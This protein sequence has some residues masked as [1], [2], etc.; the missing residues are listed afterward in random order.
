MGFDDL[1]AIGCCH[2][3][4]S[5]AKLAGIESDTRIGKEQEE[6]EKVE[7]PTRVAGIS[8]VRG[9]L[10][11]DPSD[12]VAILRGLLPG[13]SEGPTSIPIIAGRSEEQ[14]NPSRP[15]D[16][17]PS[18]LA[19]CR[20]QMNEFCSFEGILLVSSMDENNDN[21]NKNAYVNDAT[22]TD[23]KEIEAKNNEYPSLTDYHEKMDLVCLGPLTNLAQWLEEIPDF[24]SNRLN[25][26][27]ILGGNIPVP[28]LV[29]SNSIGE[30]E[31]H[32]VEDIV[33]AEFNFA[34]DPEAVR[35]VFRHA[36]L[37]NTTIHVVPQ[38]VCDR[39]AFEGSFYQE[40]NQCAEKIIEDWLQSQF[41]AVGIEYITKINPTGTVESLLPEWMVRLIRKRTFSVYGD[42]ICLYARH[43]SDCAGIINVESSTKQPRILWKDYYTRDTSSNTNKKFLSV[44]SEGRLILE[45]D[46]AS[47]NAETNYVGRTVRIAH[48][49]ELGPNYLDWLA[50]SLACPS[51]KN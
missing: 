12:G 32:S 28:T 40:G 4:S 36:G 24:A 11:S 13:A 49:V 30:G 23:S 37:Q 16:D 34:R 10:T 1:V 42:P 51:Q 25:S 15:K 7:P 18:W 2:G 29:S 5:Y 17:D 45:V 38:E 48:R 14:R 9:G 44:D 22:I 33:E 20:K 31:C 27:W 19:R 47:E 6:I 46:N 35:T 39:N 50:M 43:H 8:T 26:I 41:T 3:V 21:G